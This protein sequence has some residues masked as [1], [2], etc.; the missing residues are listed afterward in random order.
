MKQLTKTY[1]NLVN[2]LI[3]H[4]E[5]MKAYIYLKNIPSFIEDEKEVL[6][7]VGELHL[8][9]EKLRELQ[10]HGTIDGQF[11]EGFG[12]PDNI[13]KLIAY[14]YLKKLVVER[15]LKYLVDVGCFSGWIGRDLSNY[16]VR[17][18]GI[19]VNP[20]I[21]QMAKLKSTGTLATFERLPIQQLGAVHTKEFNGAIL[22]DVLEHCF[23]AE[24]VIKNVELA[25][26]DGGWV[27]I[28]LPHPQGEH[29]SDVY[30]LE[31]HEH[32]FAFSKA[33]VEKLFGKKKNLK[34]EIIEN[35]GGHIN[36]FIQY[37]I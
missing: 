15:G 8:H 29:D 17:V 18:L 19:D 7:K 11:R 16:G 32:L 3:G 9:L 36:W 31:Y 37:M 13:K 35:E 33:T 25:V 27:F 2:Y 22:F 23:D 5:L 10:N 26:K 24:T 6:N 4:G 20:L 30:E 12:N 1:M 14:Q 34:V 28:N 21:M